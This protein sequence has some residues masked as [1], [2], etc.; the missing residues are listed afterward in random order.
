MD[1]IFAVVILISLLS[2]H[3]L[4]LVFIAPILL[5]YLLHSILYFGI[6]KVCQDKYTRFKG[7]MC[8]GN[9]R[10][11]LNLFLV[12]FTWCFYTYGFEYYDSLVK[13]LL[14]TLF[15]YHVVFSIQIRSI[16]N[17]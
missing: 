11:A 9:Y 10:Y 15:I 2:M 3:R 1:L 14:V 6:N 17:K 5:L 4:P 12:F 13:G 16:L 7:L 8:I